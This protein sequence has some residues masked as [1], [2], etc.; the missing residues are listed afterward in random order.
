M[1]PGPPASFLAP[2]QGDTGLTGFQDGRA[3][4]PLA[5]ALGV[6]PG[7][8]APSTATLSGF[9]GQFSWASPGRGSEGAVF[10]ELPLLP[11]VAGGRPA[12]RQPPGIAQVQACLL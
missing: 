7:A 6:V 5:C 4:P 8:I 1:T 9:P 3:P 12:P 11:P 10:P 2:Q